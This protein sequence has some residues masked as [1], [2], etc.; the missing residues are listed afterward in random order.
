MREY[1]A[2]NAKQQEIWL[3]NPFGKKV[4]ISF[5]SGHFYRVWF[6]RSVRN[7]LPCNQVHVYDIV[8][9][10]IDSVTSSDVLDLIVPGRW[11]KLWYDLRRK[12]EANSVKLSSSSGMTSDLWFKFIFTWKVS[13]SLDNCQDWHQR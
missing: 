3:V 7:K 13:S 12:E 9:P 2:Y 5:A 8:C 1:P 6:S 4:L 10:N 11:M